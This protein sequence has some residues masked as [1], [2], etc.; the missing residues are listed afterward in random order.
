MHGPLNV[1]FITVFF[2]LVA[3]DPKIY[4][5]AKSAGGCRSL[6]MHTFWVQFCLS[7]ITFITISIQ[8]T[9]T[10]RRLVRD[11]TQLVTVAV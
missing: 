8:K 1:K 4:Q 10:N 6:Q 9:V 11:T 3:D 7:K 5:V 2:L